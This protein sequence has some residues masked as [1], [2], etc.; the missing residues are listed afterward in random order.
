MNDSPTNCNSFGIDD[1]ALTLLMTV[2]FYSQI[3]FLND[4]K[5]ILLR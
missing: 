4:Q 1:S 5:V 3:Q 2:I